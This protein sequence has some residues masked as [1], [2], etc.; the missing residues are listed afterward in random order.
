MGYEY[1]G[2]V[3]D[4]A[5]VGRYLPWARNKADYSNVEA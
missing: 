2:L 1:F 4:A 5:S 3:G